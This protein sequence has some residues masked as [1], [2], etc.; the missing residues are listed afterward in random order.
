MIGYPIADI[1][2]NMWANPN[3]TD[4]LAYSRR[5]VARSMD[6]QGIIPKDYQNGKASR[7]KL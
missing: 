5:G 7:F 6:L 1:D 3:M 2:I 4:S